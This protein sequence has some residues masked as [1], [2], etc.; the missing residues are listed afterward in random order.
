MRDGLK[1]TNVLEDAAGGE[2]RL[3][4]ARD[5]VRR[6]IKAF[7][8][9]QWLAEFGQRLAAYQQLVLEKKPQNG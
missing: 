9:G 1:G 2:T 3:I 5:E 7:V 8:D 6:I 4:L